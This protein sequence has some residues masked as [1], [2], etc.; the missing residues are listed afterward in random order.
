[1][2]G[3]SALLYD[4][5]QMNPRNVENASICY[6]KRLRLV[7]SKAYRSCTVNVPFSFRGATCAFGVFINAAGTTAYCSWGRY[8]C[9]PPPVN[10]GG[11]PRSSRCWH[12]SAPLRCLPAIGEPHQHAARLFVPIEVFGVSL[13]LLR[14]A[15]GVWCT[16]V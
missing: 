9:G 1:M 12:N 5:P 16:P 11:G 15:L 7:I 14:A 10:L 3:S 2:G 4:I 6:P 13:K 8:R